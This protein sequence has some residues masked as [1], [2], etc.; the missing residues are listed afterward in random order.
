VEEY[1]QR[2][3]VWAVAVAGFTPLPY[4]VFT[5]AAGIFRAAF[6]TFMVVSLLSRGAR[7]VGEGL[8]FHFYGAMIADFIQRYFNLLSIGFAFL[9]VLGGYAI[10]RRSRTRPG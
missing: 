2:Y 7:F 9:L 6:W 4:K 5:I 1:F 10:S 3:Q 8:L